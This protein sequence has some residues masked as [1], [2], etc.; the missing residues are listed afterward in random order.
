VMPGDTKVVSKLIE[1][2]LF[3][4]FAEFAQRNGF[5][6]ILPREQNHYPDLT[7]IDEQ[8]D[9]FAVDLKT[10]YR[11][12]PT[13]ANTMTLGAFTGYFRLRTSS[14][15]TTIPYGQYKAHIVFGVLYSRIEEALPEETRFSLDNFETMPSVIHDLAFFAQPKGKIASAT[16]GSGNTKNIGAIKNVESIVNGR[17]PF[18]SLGEQMFDLY[19]M[20]YMT[21]DMARAVDL[22]RPPYRDLLT[23]Q[24]H[25]NRGI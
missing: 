18:S 20:N 23:F 6:M 9:A 10:T 8:G 1:L 13:E 11:V 22:P 17:G 14:K 12:T 7:F 24:Q 25:F 5:K 4:T 15:N 2:M 19:W 3:P 21:L 16:P